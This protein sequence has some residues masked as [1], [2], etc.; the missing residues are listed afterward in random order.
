MRKNW[1]FIVLIL[2]F[3]GCSESPTPKN[4]VIQES[5]LPKAVS[6]SGTNM[7]LN[8]NTAIIDMAVCGDMLVIHNQRDDSI[9]MSFELPAFRCVN[10]WGDLG[11]G[12]KEY[13]NMRNMCS[14]SDSIIAVMDVVQQRIDLVNTARNTRT[15]LPILAHNMDLPGNI[16]MDIGKNRVPHIIYDAFDARS[17]QIMTSNAQTPPVMLYNFADFDKY[18]STTKAGCLGVNFERNRVIYAYNKFR[19]FDILDTLGQ[20][21]KIVEITP[22]TLP[23]QEKGYNLD[24][25]TYYFDIVTLKDSFVLSYVGYTSRQLNESLDRITYFE[26]YDYDGNPIARY[27]IPQ[28]VRSF[29]MTR[30]GKFICETLDDQYPLCVYSK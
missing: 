6:M 9:F 20:I 25:Y 18:A 2:C 22:N 17:V 13:S 24:N 14:V 30:D 27:E 10:V 5:E 7:Q 12:P 4:I 26:E 11:H 15:P 1:I 19:R 21:V 8:A 16:N 29:C 28:F 23:K 3:Q